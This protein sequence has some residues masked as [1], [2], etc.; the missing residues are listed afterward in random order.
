MSPLAGFAGV[1]FGAWLN[2]QLSRDAVR[3]E[4]EWASTQQVQ[5]RKEEAAA[6]LDAAVIESFDVAPKGEVDARDAADELQ[7]MATG[8]LQ[9]WAQNAVLD[10][11]EIA[12][13][14]HALYMTIGMA[15]RSRNWRQGVA[16][17]QMVNLWPIQ[18][19]VRELR[20]ALTCYLKRESPPP[21]K[22]PTSREL[23]R[24]VHRDGGNRF[25]AINDWLIDNEVD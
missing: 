11:P 10:D 9:A 2:R 3:E 18:V 23:I 1:G 12:R 13:R 7:P 24:I 14:F 17:V 5:Q 15:G 6:R 25:D 19:A 20:E 21:A 22:Y 8:L 16:E 4:R